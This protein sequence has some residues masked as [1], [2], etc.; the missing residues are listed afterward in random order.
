MGRVAVSELVKGSRVVLKSGTYTVAS[1]PVNT[2]NESL[3]TL[4]GLGVRDWAN[5]KTVETLTET[6]TAGQ[7]GDS[8]GAYSGRE[9]EFTIRNESVRGTLTRSDRTTETYAYLWVDG[10]MFTL[11]PATRVTVH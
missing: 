5:A 10:R 4:D 1:D 11:Y 9:V 8:Y 3:V 6:W 7:I 2:G